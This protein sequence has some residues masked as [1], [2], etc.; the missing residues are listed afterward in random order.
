MADSR[1]SVV[2]LAVWAA[3][4]PLWL[5]LTC[6]LL[7]TG[8]ELL[9]AL[10]HPVPGITLHVLLLTGLTVHGAL[11]APGPE[12]DL[13]LA[14]TL[15]PLLRLLSLSLPLASL[16][17]LA[18]IPVVALPLAVSTWFVVRLLG[19]SRRQLGLTGRGLGLQ[20]MLAAGAP[21]LAVLHFRV[22][23][24]EPLLG[25]T[26][27]GPFALAAVTLIL[28]TGFAEELIF[29][30]LLQSLAERALGGLS[31]AFVALLFAALHAGSRST[32]HVGLVLLTAYIFGYVVRWSGSILGVSLVH[33]LINVSVYLV[34]PI[35][36]RRPVEA[37]ATVPWAVWAGAALATAAVA[38]MARSRLDPGR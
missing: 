16:P 7:L 19:V 30:G 31:F 33:G 32:A 4:R 20:L 26:S 11:G 18:W 23:E 29:R 22:L 15:V 35:L 6:L 12:R 36:A 38:L 24:P 25:A 8:A 5:P 3:G 27:W 10:G 1:G 28:C 14:L 21:A 13:L 17:R 2:V 37:A 9:I 34:L